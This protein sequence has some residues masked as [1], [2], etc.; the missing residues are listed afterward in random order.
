MQYLEAE[1]NRSIIDLLWPFCFVVDA[2]VIAVVDDFVAIQ[3]LA[4][5]FGQ[6]RVNN[7]RDIALVFCLFCFLLLLITSGQMVVGGGG[8]KS[9]D[10]F[11]LPTDWKPRTSPLYAYYEKLE[12]SLSLQ[13]EDRRHPFMA[14]WEAGTGFKIFGFCLLNPKGLFSYSIKQN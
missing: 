10:N 12:R 7:R 11:T 14:C 8:V 1:K 3:K 5:K 9:F 6:N 13:K 2:V 4:I